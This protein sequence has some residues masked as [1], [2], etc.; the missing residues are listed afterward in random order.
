VIATSTARALGIAPAA[1][2]LLLSG[3]SR[4]GQGADAEAVRAAISRYD[5]LLRDGYQRQN[6]S[7]MRE[8]ASE[9]QAAKLY[10]HMAALAEGDLRM[11]AALGELRFVRIDFPAPG[12]ASAE[13]R[14]VWD[15]TH[16][17]VKTGEKYAEEKG[18]V[19]RMRYGLRRQQGRWMVSAVDVLS[20]EPT[21]TTIPLPRVDRE[22]KL[23]PPGSADVPPPQ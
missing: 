21:N 10:G 18:F 23:R 6:M 12:E 4:G 1:V 5:E 15:F 20:G 7:F 13:T 8:V 14:E 2:A 19:Y 11:S 3:C 16:Y 17:R 9:E 22:A